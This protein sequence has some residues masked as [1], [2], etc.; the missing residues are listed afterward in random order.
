MTWH[1]HTQACHNEDGGM[2]VEA[3]YSTDSDDNDTIVI[4]DD[5]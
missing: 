2:R 3:L 4:S 5:E 1:W